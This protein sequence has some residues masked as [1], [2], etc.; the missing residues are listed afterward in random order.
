MLISE[1]DD[2]LDWKQGEAFGHTHVSR[3]VRG[4]SP[5]PLTP[6]LHLHHSNFRAQLPQAQ[7]LW[8]VYLLEALPLEFFALLDSAE[9]RLFLGKNPTMKIKRALRRRD[10]FLDG[11]KKRKA[12]ALSKFH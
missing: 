10:A 6:T 2:I 12:K 1:L 9:L 5:G 4:K 7:A 3:R 11:W 8:K